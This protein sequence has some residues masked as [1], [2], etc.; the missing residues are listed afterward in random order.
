V[1]T[2]PAIRRCRDADWRDVRR[3]HVKVSL[4]FPVVVD[5]D[6]NRALATTDDQW[7]AFAHTC[8]QSADQALFVAEAGARCVGMGH[9]GLEGTVARLSMLFVEEDERRRGTGTVLATALVQWANSTGVTDCVCH[10]PEGNP[11]ERIAEGLGLHPTDEVYFT[12]HRLRERKWSGASQ[13][14]S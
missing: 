4:T 5:V 9:V 10:I 12:R 1:L 6:L 11:V 2:P 14:V 13:P 3:L 8:A 7:Q